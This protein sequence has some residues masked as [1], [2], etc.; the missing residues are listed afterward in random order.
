MPPKTTGADRAALLAKLKE[1]A[2]F[3]RLEAVRLISI[4]K[5]GHYGSA[6]SAAELFAAL[7]YHTLRLD[8]PHP[9]WPERD[10][11]VLSKG[12]AM[13][14]LYPILADLGYFPKEWLDGYTRLG[15]PLADHPDMRLIPGADFSSGSLGHGLSVAVGMALSGRIDHAPF[16]VFCMLGDGELA[17]GQVWAAA[18][19]ATHYKLGNLVGIVDRNGM[20]I[21]GFTEEVMTLEPIDEKFRAFGWD[22]KVINGHDLDEIVDT[23]E[24]LPD[25][26]SQQ[27]TMIIAKTVKGKGVPFMEYHRGW[28]VA[29]LAGEDLEYV[30]RVLSESDPPAKGEAQ[31]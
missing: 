18:M 20:S 4:A 25:P 26:Q 21:D 2:R 10:R 1:R 9:D 13:V 7:Y 14:G 22:M 31:P 16:R 27:P 28:H 6:F 15:N 12:H 3:S 23:F 19:A 17:E 30:K 5:N 8:P 29:N 11:F 24:A